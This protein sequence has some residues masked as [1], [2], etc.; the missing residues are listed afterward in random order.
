MSSQDHQALILKY[1]QED[2][3]AWY[4]QKGWKSEANKDLM[5]GIISQDAAGARKALEEGADI[6][7]IPPSSKNEYFISAAGSVPPKSPWLAYTLPTSRYDALSETPDRV[8]V[9]EALLDH[10]AD[11]LQE[12]PGPDAGNFILKALFDLPSARLVSLLVKHEPDLCATWPICTTGDGDGPVAFALLPRFEK[13]IFETDTPEK[14]LH[15]AREE[16]VHALLELGGAWDTFSRGA[17]L[18]AAAGSSSASVL[19]LLSQHGCH[20]EDISIDEKKAIEDV[21]NNIGDVFSSQTDRWDAW[22]QALGNEPAPASRR[23]A[24]P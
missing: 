16:A 15:Q 7:F 23:R 9:I 1:Y 18:T 5:R 13:P 19:D 6:N 24:A 4:A 20:I 21:I 14:G 17:V 10:G 22:K 3:A 2:T 8:G 11:P 12:L